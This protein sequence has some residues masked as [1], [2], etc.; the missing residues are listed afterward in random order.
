MPRYG[1]G[2]VLGLSQMLLDLRLCVAQPTDIEIVL[3]RLYFLARE[4][5]EAPFLALVL[6]LGFVARVIAEGLLDFGNVGNR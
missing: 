4:T 6:A 3:A 5:A 2:D 1:V